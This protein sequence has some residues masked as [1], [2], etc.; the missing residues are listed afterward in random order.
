MALKSFVVLTGQ[1]AIN[2]L[3]WNRQRVCLWRCARNDCKLGIVN[4][5]AV[6]AGIWIALELY[7]GCWTFKPR[8]CVVVRM[9]PE[10]MS[11]R[12]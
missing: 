7:D 5:I 10:P 4:P 1:G 8:D 2:M 11:A 9:R 3:S 6:Y 12:T